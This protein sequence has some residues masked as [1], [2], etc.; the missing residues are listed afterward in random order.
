MSLSDP[1]ADMLTRIR[2][3]H[4]A[5][6]DVVEMPLSR[7]KSEVA[8]VLKDE[9]YILN[10]VASG[11]RTLKLYLKYGQE[12]EPAIRGIKRE[13]KSGLRSFVSTATLPRVLGGL[14]TAVL[15]TSQGIMTARQAGERG[16]GGEYLCS[17]W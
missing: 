14:G 16:I 8:R 10:N 5:G 6:L 7:L 15:S 3:A 17:V 2:N 4:M 1:I 13:S 11:G 12:R 9:G